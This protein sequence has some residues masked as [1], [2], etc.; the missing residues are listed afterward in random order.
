M[1][2]VLVESLNTFRVKIPVLD[3]HKY[4]AL[5][6]LVEYG[7]LEETTTC[8]EEENHLIFQTSNDENYLRT[9]LTECL[10]LV[11][12]PITKL[13]NSVLYGDLKVGDKFLV[14]GDYRVWTK[15]NILEYEKIKSIGFEKSG[16]WMRDNHLVYPIETNNN[17][18]Y[19]D[20][21]GK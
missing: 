13:N 20:K 17:F 3:T 4:L 5:V 1:E 11:K 12:S 6:E 2:I 14:E 10:N 16:L 19:H 9:I 18:I 7:G 21:F 8:G 15:T